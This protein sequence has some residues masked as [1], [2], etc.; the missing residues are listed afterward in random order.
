[1]KITI[2]EIGG[3]FLKISASVQNKNHLY[4]EETEKVKF[5]HGL[6]IHDEEFLPESINEIYQLDQELNSFGKT[7][8]ILPFFI[9]TSRTFNLPVAKK[10]KINMMIPFQLD[11]SLP[12]SSQEMHWIEQIYKL[13]KKSSNVC[14]S[15]INRE[16]FEKAHS[17][18][19]SINFFP[20]TITSELNIYLTLIEV[21]KKSKKSE[22]LSID[23]I[24]N[25]NF[26]ILD[27]GENQTTAYFFSKG[28]L[29]FNHYS[30][31][32]SYNV[33]ENI[34][35][36]YEISMQEAK[37]F[38]EESG[39][40][41][42]STDY[43]NAD[44]D[45]KIFAQIMDKT[46]EPLILDFAKWDL[47]YRSKTGSSIDTC[48]IVG[49]M[50]KMRNINNYLTEHLEVTTQPLTI[51]SYSES[52]EYS[53]FFTHQ[54]VNFINLKS[55]QIGNFLKNEFRHSA[56]SSDQTETTA[57]FASKTFLLSIVLIIFL[58][59]ERIFIEMQADKARKKFKNALKSKSLNLSKRELTSYRKNKNKLKRL[60]KPRLEKI[61][62]NRK[63]LS[64]LSDKPYASLYSHLNKFKQI[65]NIQL[66][67]VSYHEDSIHTT[68][69][70]TQLKKQQDTINILKKKFGE[71]LK[72]IDNKKYEIIIR[73]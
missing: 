9:T 17:K 4:F 36:N 32:G 35:D 58:S 23:P 19:K 54:A 25:G 67:K 33:D 31:V 44:A 50:S 62:E 15:L 26:V 46:L 13:D 18:L 73:K 5:N 34:S 42:T 24:P 41:F 72:G 69:E 45:Q 8:I 30:N 27:M 68:L 40:F 2:Y 16:L 71:N 57:F 38:K 53:E 22:K 21:L 29:V 14:L 43:D 52:L 60:I 61:D 64:K 28:Q 12:S 65:D 39:F 7:I 11:E 55:G 56:G 37:I 51:N 48:F 1:M 20:T 59:I 70:I 10:N 66:E 49:G 6:N 63:I 47:A 3:V